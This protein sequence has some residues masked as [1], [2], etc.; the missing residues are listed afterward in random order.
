MADTADRPKRGPSD[1][2]DYSSTKAP[3]TRNEAE[4]EHPHP[5]D[6]R[7]QPGGAHATKWDP[8]MSSLDRDE[9]IAGGQSSG[10]EDYTKPAGRRTV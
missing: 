4:E 5:S 1:T 8:G 2:T 3:E 10:Q 6:T 9:T 7:L